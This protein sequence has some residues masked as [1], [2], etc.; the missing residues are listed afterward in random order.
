MMILVSC[1]G[2]N[3]QDSF[4]KEANP[5]ILSKETDVLHSNTERQI[6]NHN[7]KYNCICHNLDCVE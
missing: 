7:Q 6:L 4:C 2:I 1:C 3:G 5:I